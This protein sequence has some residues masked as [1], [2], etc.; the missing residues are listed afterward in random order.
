MKHSD[1]DSEFKMKD[2]DD[3]STNSEEDIKTDV[4]NGQLRTR[5]WI[6]LGLDAFDLFFLLHVLKYVIIQ[7]WASFFWRFCIKIS[8]QISDSNQ[9]ERSP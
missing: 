6:R 3:D 9:T 2:S 4:K 7:Y 1:S 8:P 5:L